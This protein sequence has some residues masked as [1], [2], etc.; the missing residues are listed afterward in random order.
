MKGLQVATCPWR[1][2][3]VGV[4]QADDMLRFRQHA[5]RDMKERYAGIIQTVWSPAEK[6]L[7]EYNEPGEE[8]NTSAA[9]FR[10]V[11]DRMNSSP[12]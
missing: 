5:T 9:C 3:E 12:E 11:F 2:P 4:M 6:F 10:A 8:K 7:K 1:D